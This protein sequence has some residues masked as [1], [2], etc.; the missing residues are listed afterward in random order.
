MFYGRILPVLLT[1]SP[2]CSLMTGGAS[3]GSRRRALHS[4][5]HSLK[6]SLLMLLKC[7]HSNSLPVR[8][9]LHSTAGTA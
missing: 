3:Q 5:V 6:Y 8:H 2:D 1:L 4:V 9:A 7:N